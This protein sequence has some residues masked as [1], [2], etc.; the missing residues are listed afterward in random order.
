MWHKHLLI[1]NTPLA[2]SS[3][4][5]VSAHKSPW[6]PLFI[7]SVNGDI[8]HISFTT[9]AAPPI[10]K[11][12][13]LHLNALELILTGKTHHPISLNPQGTEFQ[14][15]VWQAI[16]Q[17]PWGQRASYGDIAKAIG[18]PRA[19]RAVGTAT[20]KNPIGLLI[21]CHRVVPSSGGAGQ[22]LWGSTLK[23]AL[24]DWESTNK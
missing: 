5:I 9:P 22:Y 24:L 14:R 10:N 11:P 3:H 1:T 19:V 12:S 20:G 18:N 23:S 21:P 17:I 16:G 7:T 4:P 8:T 13:E 15:Q 2:A 6:G